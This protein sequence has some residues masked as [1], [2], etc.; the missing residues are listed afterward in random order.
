MKQQEEKEINIKELYKPSRTKQEHLKRMMVILI[1]LSIGL[2]L[3]VVASEFKYNKL[4]KE[5]NKVVY[6]VNTCR[7][8]YMP[9]SFNEED[10][11]EQSFS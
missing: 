7:T 3:V 1:V 9:I 8:K 6:E 2:C 11:Y 10:R 4:V 5:Y